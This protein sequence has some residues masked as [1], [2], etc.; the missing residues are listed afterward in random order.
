MPQVECEIERI[1]QGSSY[2][3]KFS[4]GEPGL[5]WM[6]SDDSRVGPYG[7][8]DT[9]LDLLTVA[10]CIF[11]IE[12]L[13]HKNLLTNPP[14]KYTLT[15]PMYQPEK[16]RQ[17]QV[18]QALQQ[19]LTCLDDAEWEFIFKPNDQTLK[20]KLNIETN[21]DVSIKQI[22]LFSGGMDST[23]GVATIS[24]E[25]RKATRY[26]SYYTRQYTAQNN[27]LKDL[28]ISDPSALTSFYSR[29]KTVVVENK[30]KITERKNTNKSFYYRSFLFMSLGA[31]IADSWQCRHLIQF[32]N[33]ILAN[34]VSPTPAILMTKHAHPI[35]HEY[36]TQLLSNLY[37]STWT[38]KNPFVFNTKNEIH[39][40]ALDVC[41][42][43]NDILIKAETCWYHYANHAL[44]GK[45]NAN[46]PC[47]ICIPC[48]IRLTADSNYSSICEIDILD[49]SVQ[50]DAKKGFAF[51]SYQGFAERINVC[52][53][54]N[55][56]YLR[57]LDSNT[58]ELIAS[59]WS[60]NYQSL[61]DVYKRF[62]NEFIQTFPK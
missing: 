2:T 62:S 19:L 25:E 29:C 54:K 23:C 39:Q 52:K 49:K 18:T 61:Y 41:P 3:I 44:V 12:K 11:H 43:F 59:G 17:P 60:V 37:D 4:L 13:L 21:A 5:V 34:A 47:G 36:F 38:L 6:L 40:F 51:R 55:D 46:R 8:S 33:G 32:E 14:K 15:V 53:D 27:I 16:W 30:E 50:I 42:K 58:R 10:F 56:F 31:V 45:K 1:Q 35:L 26:V 24:S 48:I 57:V 9:S 7:F 28:G 22:A 20:P